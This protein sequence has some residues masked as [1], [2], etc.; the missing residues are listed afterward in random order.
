MVAPEP[1]RIR[2]S[3]SQL[4]S[5]AQCGEQYRLERVAKA[6][7]RP[8]SWFAHGHAAHSCIEAWEVGGRSWGAAEMADSFEESY[9]TEIKKLQVKWPEWDAWMTGG[10]K[11]PE[12][13]MLDRLTLGRYQVE[14]YHR[15]ATEA[16]DEWRV[17]ASEVEFTIELGHVEV[18]GFIDAVRQRAD[19]SIEVADYKSGSSTPGSAAQLAV[20][21]I[22]VEEYMGVR[23]QRGAFIKLA[24]MK[25]GNAKERPTTELEHDLTPWT[26]ELL[27]DMFRDMDR[28][29]SRGIYLPSPTDDCTRTC[30]VSQWCRVPGRGHAESAAQFSTIRSREDYFA[31]QQKEVA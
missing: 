5:Y 10:R 20:Y 19:G 13:D 18:Y 14:E 2:R 17:I 11:K 21:G 24:R 9:D 28:A 30:G 16:A 7:S 31:A 4:T 22:A 29:E 27:A 1:P 12:Q 26:R 25:S 3:V 23:P 8:A 15:Y 6:P